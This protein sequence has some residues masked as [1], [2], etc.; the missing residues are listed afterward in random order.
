VYKQKTRIIAR[1]LELSQ[2][3]REGKLLLELPEGEPSGSRRALL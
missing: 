2:L 1:L 3:G